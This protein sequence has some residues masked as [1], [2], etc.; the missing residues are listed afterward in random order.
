MIRK[1]AVATLA[2]VACNAANA[3]L[4][5]NGG[6]ESPS[7]IGGNQQFNAGSNAIPGWAITGGSVDLVESGSVLGNAHSGL[8]LIDINGASAGTIQQ[9]FATKPGNTYSVELYYSN[10]PNPA[11]ARPSYSASVTAIGSGQLFQQTL[12]H[13]GATETEM[14]WLLFTRTFVA[15]SATT[16]LRLQSSQSGFNGIYFDSVSVVPEPS[17]FAIAATSLFALSLNRRRRP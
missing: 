4:I 12:V 9:T 13:A 2:L 15:N 17:A 8:Q 11:E 10:N 3:D 6:F 1:M 16:T 5:V 7:V 14:N